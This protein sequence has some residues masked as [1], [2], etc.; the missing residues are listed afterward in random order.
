MNITDMCATIHG[1]YD[2]MSYPVTEVGI[3]NVS[4]GLAFMTF[5]KVPIYSTAKMDVP[6]VV[7]VALNAI[8]RNKFEIQ[9]A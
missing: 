2:N 4:L 7:S 5:P 9:Q 6:K 3:V 8:M 1:S